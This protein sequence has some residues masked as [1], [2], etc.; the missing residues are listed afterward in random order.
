M[1]H[2]EV[3]SAWGVCHKDQNIGKYGYIRNI[4]NIGG[5]FYKISKK[6]KLYKMYENTQ[7]EF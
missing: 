6:R 1:G 3:M 2:N 4:I 7:K 5:Y